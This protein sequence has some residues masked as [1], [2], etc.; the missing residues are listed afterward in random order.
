MASTIRKAVDKLKRQRKYRHNDTGDGK[1]R[2]G[3][4]KKIRWR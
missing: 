3:K 4:R 2:K 1:T